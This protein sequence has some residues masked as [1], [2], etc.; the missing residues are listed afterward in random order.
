MAQFQGSID[1]EEI[2][3]LVRGER[4]LAGLLEAVLNQLL[5]AEMTEHLGAGR[6][7][8]SDVRRGRRNGHYRRSLVTRVGS[9]ELRVPR[10]REGAFRTE[11]FERYQ[12][13][14]KALVLALL[15]MVINGVSTRKVARITD[16]LCGREFKRSTVSDLAKQLDAQVEAWSERPLEGLY[17]FL[18]V[19]A[20]Q[21]KVRRDEA[22][23]PTS[24]LIAI[25]VNAEGYREI[26]GIHVADS[27]S[28]QSWL[29]LFG[30][31]KRRGL[32][33]VEFAVSDAHGGLASALQ[34]CFQ[35]VVW[36][37]CQVHFRRNVVDRASKKYHGTL[38]RALDRILGA[39]DPDEARAAFHHACEQLEGKVDKA[40][41]ILEAG[42]ED[43]IQVLTLPDKYQVRLRSTNMLERLIQ[44][45]RRR[46]KVIRIF[47]NERSAWRLLGALLAE[48]HEIWSTG[49][50]WLHMDT[51]WEWKAAQD[52]KQ[53][54]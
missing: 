11:L 6:H 47:P 24:V 46:E 29:E 32:R 49:R 51:F 54:A 43:A 2:K 13:S 44:E 18:V 19:D 10:D 41:Q 1:R 39:P 36:Q 25:G 5:E 26:L 20:M 52:L 40:L 16:E 9:I 38:Q 12:R 4:G 17:P 21:I 30:N 37:R 50:R 15:E 35:G 3:R 8:R 27:E 48:Q 31:L 34:R 28:E 7:E 53:A 14:E 33:G 23:R 42:L 22:V 45:A